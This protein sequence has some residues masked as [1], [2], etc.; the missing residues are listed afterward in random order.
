MNSKLIFV[1]MM[2][3]VFWTFIIMLFMAYKRFSAG[4][5][6]RLKPGAFKVGE[7]PEVPRD[8]RLANRNFINLFEMPV[9]F[10]ALCLALYATH[11]VTET[12]LVLS[13]IYVLLRMAHSAIHVSY[14]KILHRFS[15]Y[16]A[17]SF[18]LLAMWIIFSVALYRRT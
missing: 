11:N 16:A 10:Y 14:N 9:L 6:G 5:A 18:V 17:S 13:W 1:P 7:S 12:L 15:V 8:V 2:A 3:L 4:F